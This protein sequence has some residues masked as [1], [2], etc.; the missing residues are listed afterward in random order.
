MTS[1][2][3]VYVT[4]VVPG[5]P[6]WEV[7]VVLYEKAEPRM[8]RSGFTKYMRTVLMDEKIIWFRI[9]ELSMKS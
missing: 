8:S 9:L 5:R 2:H 1:K 3:S 4:D 7:K 6:G